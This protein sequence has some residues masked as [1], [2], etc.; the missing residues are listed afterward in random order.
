MRHMLLSQRPYCQLIAIILPV[1]SE[2]VMARLGCSRDEKLLF[3]S[4]F[5]CLSTTQSLCLARLSNSKIF[6]APLVQND[7]IRGYLW[8]FNYSYSY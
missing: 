8:Q 6:T 1:D 5:V 4:C 3:F 2:R 7:H